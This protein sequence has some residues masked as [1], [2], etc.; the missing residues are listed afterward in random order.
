[1][2]QLNRDTLVDA[3]TRMRTIRDFED[4]IHT[5]FA[6]GSIP[7]FVHLYAGEEASAVGVCLNLND[8][9]YIASTHRGHGHCIAKGCDVKSMMRVFFLRM[10]RPPSST[11][12]P[13]TPPCRTSRAKR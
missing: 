2:L 4:R 8:A 13:Y 3:Y 6:T 7:G 10:R 5:E 9:D 12:C 1:M 11:L